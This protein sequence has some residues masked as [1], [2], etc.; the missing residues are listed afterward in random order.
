[1]TARALLIGAVLCIVLGL[2]LPFAEFYV[3][4]TRLGLSSATPAAFFLLFIILIG[5]QLLLK[6]VRP[7]WAFTRAELLTIFAMMSMATVVCTRGFVGPLFGIITG[8]S[9]YAQGGVSWAEA[10]SPYLTAP[11]ALTD[12]EAARRLYEG[13][14]PGEHIVWSAWLRP[15]AWW[16]FFALCMAVLSLSAVAIL[17]KQWIDHEHLPF[18][19]ARVA[20]SLAEQG[21]EGSLINPLF[22]SAAFWMGFAVPFVI[23]SLNGLHAYFPSVPQ[24]PL[25]MNVQFRGELVSALIIR[26]SFLMLG[27]AFFIDSRVAFS[28][29]VFYLLSLPAQYVHSMV[30]LGHAESLGN[31]TAPGPHGTIAAHQQMGAMLVLAGGMVWAARKHLLHDR[32]AVALFLVSFAVMCIM[33]AQMGVPGLAAPL[34]VGCAVVIWL[35]LT[36]LMVQGGMATIV[37][38]IIPLG[39]VISTMGTSRLGPVGTVAMGLTLVWA[40]DLLTFPM[41]PAANSA[42]LD[43]EA[44]RKRSFAFLPLLAAVALGLITAMLTTLWLAHSLGGLNLHLQYFEWFPRVTWEYIG[45]ELKYAK[46]PSTTGYMWTGVGAGVMTLLTILSRSFPWWPLHPLGYLAQGGWIMEQLWFSIFLAWLT[47][48]AVLRIGGGRIY[49]KA[50]RVFIGIIVGV[51]VVGGLWLVVNAITGK[52]AFTIS[53]Y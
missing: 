52:M 12:P 39:F 5:P 46:P 18:P 33:V 1:V 42:F 36:R 11:F 40:G 48:V 51:L 26:V 44:S 29:W 13:L 47:K 24:L 3:Q 10:V 4:G 43:H 37:P 7:K 45:M 27:F 53:V 50:T 30:F 8:P 21:P 14:K 32:R 22:R 35:S 19:V 49:K 41:G 17:R 6:W 28:L 15:M 38:A 34:A 20:L 2:A 23:E 25:S 9:Y 31:W 16:S